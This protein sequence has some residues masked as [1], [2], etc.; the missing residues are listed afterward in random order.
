M[1]KSVRD[2]KKERGEYSPQ[3]KFRRGLGFFCDISQRYGFR[4]FIAR[5]AEEMNESVS[6]DAT[7][8]QRYCA[9]YRFW[10][11]TAILRTLT[12]KIRNSFRS[13]KMRTDISSCVK[14]IHVYCNSLDRACTY[15][16]KC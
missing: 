12:E 1:V 9:L 15:H 8:T 13:V 11:V 2:K 10:F 4:G 5:K 7:S 16:N 6:K 3:F 14:T